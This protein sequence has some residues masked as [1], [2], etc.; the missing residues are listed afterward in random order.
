M[1]N[2]T[3]NTYLK[4]RQSSTARRLVEELLDDGIEPARIRI[5]A[6]QPPDLPVPSATYRT[7]GQAIGQGAIIGAGTPPFP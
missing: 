7:P 3:S 2:M 6:Q 4:T 5:H 1:A